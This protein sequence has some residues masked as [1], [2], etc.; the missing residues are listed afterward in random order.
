AA[1]QALLRMEGRAT[2]VA[3]AV[4]NIDEADAVAARIQ[5]ALGDEYEAASWHKV[6]PAVDDIIQIQNSFLGT[7]IYV[8]LFVAMIGIANA[9]VMNVLER[10]REIGTMMAVGTRRAQIMQ[11]FLSEAALLGLLGGIAGAAAGLAA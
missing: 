8:F 5:A 1:A 3:V 7:I 11:L 10:T 2:E 4:Y 9:M 6:M